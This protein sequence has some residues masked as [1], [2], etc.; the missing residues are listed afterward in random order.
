MANSQVSEKL[1]DTRGT[2]AA[3]RF[4]TG[5]QRRRLSAIAVLALL[6]GLT[7]ALFLLT[8]T[9]AAFAIALSSRRVGIVASRYLSINE[10][11]ILALGLLVVRTVLSMSSLSLSARLVTDVVA[12]LRQRLTHAYMRAPWDRQQDQ[13]AGN[14][15]ELVVGYTSQAANLLNS[16]S[17]A[18]VAGASLLA[19]LALSVAVDPLG[20]CW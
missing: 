20:A 18:V 5:G 12:R 14:L 17:Q 7:E 8:I 13:D 4:V 3:I 1:D 11:L 9:R 2:R 6:G 15:Q 10:T 19:M 16:V